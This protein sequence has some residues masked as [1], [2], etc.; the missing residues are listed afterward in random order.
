[1]VLI[2]GGRVRHDERGAVAVLAALLS[3][4]MLMASGLVVDLGMAWSERAQAQNA[5]D[6]SALAAGNALYADGTGTP[7]IDGAVA[8]AESY[9]ARNFGVAT[10]A[11][12]SCTDTGALPYAPTT[13]CVSFDDATRPTQV[14]VTIPVRDVSSIFAGLVGVHT[15]RI[16]AGATAG[17]DAGADVKCALCVVGGGEHTMSNGLATIEGSSVHFNGYID[18][19]VDVQATGTDAQITLE[20]S[21]QK[22]TP[23]FSPTPIVD[24]VTMADPLAGRALPSDF[25][26][27]PHFADGTSP[28]NNPPGVYGS[29]SFPGGACPLQNGLYVLTGDWKLGNKTVL[30]GSS[31]SLYATCGTST[32]PQPCT[33]GALGGEFDGS[34]GTTTLSGSAS[35]LHDIAIAYDRNDASEL[36]LQGNADCAVAGTVY[37]LS[38]RLYLNGNSSCAFSAGAIVIGDLYLNG[39]TTLDLKSPV[40]E[41]WTLPPSNLHLTQ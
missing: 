28:C 41:D 19:N 29:F 25:S 20:Q 31:V 23:T 6:A 24:G 22:P 38:A 35:Q 12:T 13:P 9:A 34:N 7:D 4:V 36:H 37:A 5:A 26:G 21:P 17:L 32:T 18:G 2:R 3:S 33:P 27:L 10:A 15:F 11:W 16:D 40:E 8:A 1:V 14:R 39:G 30:T